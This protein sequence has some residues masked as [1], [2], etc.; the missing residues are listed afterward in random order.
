MKKLII[1]AFI[2]TC[3][4]AATACN[5][6]SDKEED[7]VEVAE[8]KNEKMASNDKLEEDHEFMVKAASGGMMEVELGNIAATN[9][10]SPKVKEFAQMMVTDH[11]KANEEVK[12]LAAAKNITLP[13]SPGEKH[14]KHIDDLK[15]KQGAAFDKAYMEMMVED[16]EDDIKKFEKQSEK[17]ND[18]DI[19]NLAAGKVAILKHHHEMAKAVRD[20]LKN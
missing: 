1:P 7:T 18:P 10:A 8:E 12:A 6:K 14:Q 5:T 4:F 17:G 9:A 3:F 13:A 11:T 2:A 19:K 15:S 20:G 16:H